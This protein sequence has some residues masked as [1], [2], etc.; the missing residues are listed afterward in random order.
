MILKI[1]FIINLLLIVIIIIYNIELYIRIFIFGILR[2]KFLESIFL[3]ASNKKP[4]FYII[5][6]RNAN[7]IIKNTYYI[8]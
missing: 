1:C 7:N 5:T 6:N 3:L 2:T 4:F 8:K